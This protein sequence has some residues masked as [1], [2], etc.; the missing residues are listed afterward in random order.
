MIK[1]NGSINLFWVLIYALIFTSCVSPVEITPPVEMDAEVI[2]EP[3]Q[4]PPPPEPFCG[5]GHWDE[6]EGEEC[7][8]GDDNELNECLPTCVLARCGDGLLRQDLPENDGA[9]EE[10]DDGN[11]N[12]RDDCLSNC[13][14]SQCGDGIVHD[15]EEECDDGNEDPTDGCFECRFTTCGD[16]VTRLGLSPDDA[17]YEECDDGN[18]DD[19]DECLSSCVRSRCGDGI[20]QLGV[21]QCDDGDDDNTD[22]CLNTCQ[23]PTCGD[24]IVRTDLEVGALGY[25]EC[26]DGDEDNS[27]GCL[28][29]CMTARCGDR[30]L[31]EGIEMCD[32]GQN[33][34]PLD[35]C[36]DDCTLVSCGDGIL[37]PEIGEECDDGENNIDDGAC[38]SRCVEAR[39]GDAIIRADLSADME[40]FEGCDDG[41]D[42]NTDG[43]LTSCQRA[44]CGDGYLLIGVEECDPSIEGGPPC[45]EDCVLIECGNQ[46][47]QEGEECDDGNLYNTD[48]CLNSCEVARC[49]DGYVQA[50]VERCD[51]EN[52]ED[53]DECL[54]S[55]TTP[56][57]R[58]QIPRCGDGI[59]RTDLEEGEVGY[60]ECDGD[61]DDGGRCDDTCRLLTC[62]NGAL[63]LYT[64]LNGQYTQEECDDPEVEG[65]DAFCTE[66]IYDLWREDRSSQVSVYTGSHTFVDQSTVAEVRSEDSDDPAQGDHIDT[67]NFKLMAP[68]YF[69]V[70]LYPAQGVN[71]TASLDDDELCP[72]GSPSEGAITLT[73]IDELGT[74]FDLID[75]SSE[76]Q[77][78]LNLDQDSAHLKTGA[79]T[80]FDTASYL[81]LPFDLNGVALADINTQVL[82]PGEY[83]LSVR[84]LGQTPADPTSA[85]KSLEKYALNTYVGLDISSRAPFLFPLISPQDTDAPYAV[86]S[87]YHFILHD[88]EL[89]ASEDPDAEQP[90]SRQVSLILTPNVSDEY[91]LD[92]LGR[93]T[94][95]PTV[96]LKHLNQIDSID[97][98]ELANDPQVITVENLTDTLDPK[99]RSQY[100]CQWSAT[101]HEAGLFQ[102]EMTASIE[103]SGSSPT[104]DEW[105]QPQWTVR[106][107][108]SDECGNGVLDSNE[109]CDPSTDVRFPSCP[110]T[111]L[112]YP[113]QT[114]GDQIC[115]VG[116][117]QDSPDCQPALVDEA[118]AYDSTSVF[119]KRVIAQG[120]THTY[121]FMVQRGEEEL[122][123]RLL[124]C[125]QPHL[126]FELY[127]L[128]EEDEDADP[129]LITSE[130]SRL[131]ATPFDA[132]CLR[133][134]QSVTEGRYLLKTQVNPE[135]LGRLPEAPISYWVDFH[136]ATDLPTLG[137]QSATLY[138]DVYSTADPTLTFE[139]T[140]GLFS[141]TLEEQTNLKIK[142]YDDDVYRQCESLRG[143]KM[144]LLE[145]DEAGWIVRQWDEA[146][147]VSSNAEVSQVF[148]ESSTGALLSSSDLEDREGSEVDRAEASNS[149]DG[150]GAQ[151]E[152]VSCEYLVKTLPAGR[153]LIEVQRDRD[154][155][156]DVDELEPPFQDMFVTDSYVL[157]LSRP[158][159]CGNGRQ[160]L[161][162][163]C[164]D[165]NFVN[166]DGCSQRCIIE[167]HCG[168]GEIQRGEECDDGNVVSGDLT[169]SEVCTFCGDGI[170]GEGEE[171][172]DGNV[173]GGDG[174]D[175]ICMKHSFEV[176]KGLYE[177]EQSITQ[178][179]TKEWT[180]SPLIMPPQRVQLSEIPPPSHENPPNSLHLWVCYNRLLNDQSHPRFFPKLYSG[181][182]DLI[183]ADTP[184]NFDQM[185]LTASSKRWTQCDQDL[186]ETAPSQI[187]MIPDE[188]T[189]EVCGY[190]RT[191]MNAPLSSSEAYTLKLDLDPL[192]PSQ[193]AYA[194]TYR[195]K[196]LRT[197]DLSTHLEESM[198]DE[199]G[200]PRP[201]IVHSI[202]S[203]VNFPFDHDAYYQITPKFQEEDTDEGYF[204]IRTAEQFSPPEECPDYLNAQMTLYAELDDDDQAPNGSE[205]CE[206]VVKVRGQGCDWS[207]AKL[208]KDRSYL[209]HIEHPESVTRFE[210]INETHL[211]VFHRY[212]ENPYD[213]EL[214]PPGADLS[215][216]ELCGNGVLD[217]GEE[218]D[219]GPNPDPDLVDSCNKRCLRDLCLSTGL[220]LSCQFED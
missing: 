176:T 58:C 182:G 26:D 28:N 188:E 108:W 32:D 33:G 210:P 85:V 57:T 15:G 219:P 117:S 86:R 155:H 8:D 88:E 42:D 9:F 48:E 207:L 160:D 90:R 96:T 91:P 199:Q 2:V 81:T 51:D 140:S 194:Y 95:C 87:H 105:T 139:K 114:E 62:G 217:Y 168:D 107:M 132:D 115:D 165:G 83:Q 49:G 55:G 206:E 25:E 113:S 22:E 70:G 138:Q 18:D 186:E 152:E 122:H 215:E 37:T 23:R 143:F 46:K 109:E 68:A 76:T 158:R 30:V 77:D 24:R 11:T 192:V 52:T 100:V 110:D 102:F 131:D 214:F 146:E 127:K 104:P 171:C 126:M 73:R 17:D 193:R 94:E 129:E 6:E 123:A 29:S 21:E 178:S 120:Q 147:E 71:L 13:R 69:R 174:C 183:N 151:N 159:L 195:M 201:E 106:Y 145:A 169:C 93:Y 92:D 187:S 156:L 16:G 99:L 135:Q 124:Y 84:G 167:S 20:V 36:L 212:S 197:I 148:T 189:E 111:C 31:H 220:A 209:I 128:N 150:I 134:D 205:Y 74:P 45:D 179:Q 59:H 5:D 39:C 56:E 173:E 1:F 216:F 157:S 185:D 116:E 47:V 40:G 149:T 14:L 142:T 162:E 75:L 175:E 27:D 196:L 172:D 78:D 218:C 53:N 3:D 7:D 103:G 200:N 63:E 119:E 191:P 35:G 101:V 181:A 50:G 60:E 98:I 66:S 61:T 12:D 154:R 80:S 89:L 41:N 64:A 203:R 164:D 133:L 43:C 97:L 54:S 82:A 141:F 204:E 79:C 211:R 137:T 112:R 67:Y 10:C 161:G 118:D 34:D 65:C 44:S 153:Y 144:R 125:S 184:L 19:G 163:E 208:T 177:T 166:D 38:T 136:H 190:W 202:F 180:L 4:A 130:L 170:L 213:A 72:S 121:E 198:S